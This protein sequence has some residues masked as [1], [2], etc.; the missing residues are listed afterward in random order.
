MFK[1]LKEKIK[2]TTST[3]SRDTGMAMVLIFLILSLL[4]DD[5]LFIYIAVGLLVIN[6]VV[7]NIYK[8]LAVFWFGLSQIIGTVVSKVLLT[9][10]FFLLVTPVGIIRNILGLDSLDLKKWKDSKDSVFKTRNKTFKIEDIV[11]PY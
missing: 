1:A 9:I 10:I 4:T 8:A 5:L 6:M 11:K 2:K 3:Q 7:P